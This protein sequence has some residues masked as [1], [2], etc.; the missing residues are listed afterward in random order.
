MQEK[1]QLSFGDI[2]RGT[3]GLMRDMKKV[4]GPPLTL[5]MVRDRSLL[6]K[7]SSKGNTFL[8]NDYL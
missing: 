7:M 5:S 1:W 8:T 6:K 4:N 3:Y 2:L